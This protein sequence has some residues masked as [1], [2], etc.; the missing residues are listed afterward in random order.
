MKKL[1]K[2][3][4]WF[5]VKDAA[6]LATHLLEESVKVS[7]LL[8]LSVDGVLPISV[9]FPNTVK[10][11]PAD[12]VHCSEATVIAILHHPLLTPG[13]SLGFA[14]EDKY[15]NIIAASE[16]ELLE[17]FL[18]SH[19][20][21][22]KDE[23]SHMQELIELVLAHEQR[24]NVSVN[25]VGVEVPET[26]NFVQARTSTL[27]H[28]EG[29]YKFPMVGSNSLDMKDEMLKKF[30]HPF[31][32]TDITLD[33]NW[34][35]SPNGDWFQLA[36]FD[37]ISKTEKSS[38][39]IPQ[40]LPKD[41]IFVYER[42]ELMNFLSSLDDT[43]KTN[44]RVVTKDLAT[45]TKNKLVLTC[46]ALALCI[47]DELDDTPTASQLKAIKDK[48][49]YHHNDIPCSDPTLREYLTNPN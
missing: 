39:P 30:K 36:D 43:Q 29:T 46:R 7:D 38:T 15:E 47:V 20:E 35:V 1:S 31:K 37:W 48:M 16:K 13:N 25:F 21:L 33:G 26:E 5:T 6:K 2:L 24:I 18:L 45:K 23:K 34:V 10:A 32:V 11:L 49:Q 44:S 14:I 40:G 8:Q 41:S 28:L 4:N 17:Q 9:Y 22:Q 42:E 3:K 27:E 19:E 12:E